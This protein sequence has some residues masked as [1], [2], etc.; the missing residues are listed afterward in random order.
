MSLSGY[1]NFLGEDK[2]SV[3]FI[4]KGKMLMKRGGKMVIIGNDLYVGVD[5]H[6]REKNAGEKYF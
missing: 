3:E 5:V 6:Y 4:E 2:F 1:E